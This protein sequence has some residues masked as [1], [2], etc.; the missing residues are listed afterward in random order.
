MLGFFKNKVRNIT[1]KVK[2]SFFFIQFRLNN[3][4]TL[5]SLYHEYKYKQ[6]LVVEQF[7][8]CREL[9][10]YGIINYKYKR[11]VITTSLFFYIY[12]F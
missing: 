7:T 8:S 12:L 3:Q 6:Y 10:S 5:I 4:I 9:S 1:K 11:L 2:S